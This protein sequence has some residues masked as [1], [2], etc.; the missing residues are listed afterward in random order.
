MSIIDSEELYSGLQA[1]AD[2]TFPKRCANCGK[3]FATATDFVHETETINN[4]S[5]FKQSYGDEGEKI[6]ELY[7]NCSCGSTLLGFFDDRRDSS[8]AGL[9]R[10]EKFGIMLEK[11]KTFGLTHEVARTELL[12]VM[13]GHQSELLNKLQKDLA[14]K[15][16]KS[17]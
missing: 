1:L 12:K 5:G 16:D 10:R 3:I 15:T 11:L 8:E 2:S 6:V 4:K 13:R 17:T 7:R 9:K 14:I